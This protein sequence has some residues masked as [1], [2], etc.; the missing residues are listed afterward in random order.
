MRCRCAAVAG[1]VLALIAGACSGGGDSSDSDT[2]AAPGGDSVS[3]GIEGCEAQSPVTGHPRLWIAESDLPALRAAATA[4]NPVYEFGLRAAALEAREEMDLGELVAGDGGSPYWEEY[5]NENYAQLF[6]FMALVAPD[7]ERADWACRARALL[8]RVI[9]EAAKGVSDSAY[10][11]DNFALTD[12]SRYWGSAYGLTVDW[13]YPYLSDDD[14]ATI[15]DVFL[16]WSAENE[17]AETTTLNH[18]EPVGVYNDPA[19]VQDSAAVRF[20]GNNYYT[21]HMRNLG[22][23]ALALDPADDSSGELAAYLQTA[24]GAYLYVFDHLT[25]NDSAGGQLAEGFEYSP[26][27]AAYASQLLLALNTAGEDDPGEHGPQVEMAANPF[28][29]DAVVAYVHSMSPVPVDHPDR[30]LVYEPATFGDAQDYF[31]FDPI[32]MLGP[33]GIHAAARG[34][35]RIA[36]L[37]R[38]TQVHMTPGGADELLDR[39]ANPIESFAETILYFLLFPPG[40]TEPADVRPEYP[41]HFFASGSNRVLARTD[42]SD[43]ASWFVYSLPW[44]GVDHQQAEANSVEFYRDGEWLTRNRAGY[45]FLIGNTDWKNTASVENDRPDRPDDDYRI[46]IWE[47]GSQWIAD[48]EIGDPELLARSF[49]DGFVLVTGDATNLYN[50]RHEG[51]DSVSHVSR[52]VVWIEP[53]HIVVYDRAET[54]VEDR[55][56]R[57]FVQLVGPATVA[58]QVVTSVTPGG[59]QLFVSVLLPES[60]RIDVSPAGSVT[61]DDFGEE[62]A[63]DDPITHRIRIDS[64]DQGRSTRFLQ[65]LQGADGGATLDPVEFVRSTDGAFEGVVVNGHVVLFRTDLSSGVDSVIYEVPMA[66]VRHLVT[67]LEPGAS[68]TVVVEPG[69]ADTIRV[70]VTPGGPETAGEGGE[71]DLRL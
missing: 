15:R 47:A 67:G 52:S 61:S 60:A 62:V 11:A 27:T 68:Y 56:K 4:E 49:G 18:P 3:A 33:I 25:R 5:P 7:A 39:I 6:A 63:N 42:W 40:T 21:A 1:V 2:P 45:G 65:V 38:W 53:D 46:G 8:M 44:L 19:L 36:E 23:M 29:E 48:T 70:T 32:E 55:F 57:V 10:R 20:A 64:E 58:G 16:R 43:D 35:E 26:Q 9:D 30:G 69:S 59:Q 54:V 50:S 12:R 14:K 17:V 71:L 37:V 41:T 66:A 13:I 24:V 34:D 22:L 28:Y 31:V 51:I